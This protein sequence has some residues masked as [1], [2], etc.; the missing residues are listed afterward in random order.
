VGDS[1]DFSLPSLLDRKVPAD[2]IGEKRT[3][4]LSLSL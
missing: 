3:R 2:V 4:G 1:K